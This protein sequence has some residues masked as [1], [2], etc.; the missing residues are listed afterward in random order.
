MNPKAAA[1]IPAVR[2]WILLVDDEE[3]VRMMIKS[4][5]KM[6]GYQVVEAEDGIDALEKFR[7]AS[8]KIE[9]VLMD[10]RKP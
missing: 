1:K 2:E 9:L 6:R 10:S 3:L 7:M 4:V 8:P 5:L